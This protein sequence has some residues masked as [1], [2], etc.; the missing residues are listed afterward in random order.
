M[1]RKSSIERGWRKNHQWKEDEER[2]INRKRMKRKASI[3]R[4]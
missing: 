3:E 1:K 4:G 2:S